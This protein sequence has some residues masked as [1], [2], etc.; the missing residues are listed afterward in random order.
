MFSPWQGEG[1]QDPQKLPGR[2]KNETNT[3]TSACL[4]GDPERH[5]YCDRAPRDAAIGAKNFTEAA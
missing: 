2:I 4:Q 5:A 3:M 1:L